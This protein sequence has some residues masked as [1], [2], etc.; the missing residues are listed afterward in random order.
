MGC[1]KNQFTPPLLLNPEKNIYGSLVGIRNGLVVT[2][3]LLGFVFVQRRKLLP[4]VVLIALLSTIHKST[5][6][7]LPIAYFIGRNKPLTIM[8]I[9]G[10]I[11]GF[12]LLLVLGTSGIVDV[13]ETIVANDYFDRYQGYVASGKASGFLMNTSSFVLLIV[14]LVYLFQN[15]NNLTEN[16][17]SIIRMGMFFLVTNVMG[18]LSARSSYFYDMFF[19]ASVVKIVSEKKITISYRVALAL[20]VIL[21][22]SYSMFYVWMGKEYFSHEIY[23]SLIGDW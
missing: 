23:H 15:R 19:I 20:F 17:N 8:E 1:L 21:I 4:F 9:C 14:F 6:L 16:D 13:L 5:L 11:L 10:W 22:S 7:F 12:V 2:C 3:F 18:S